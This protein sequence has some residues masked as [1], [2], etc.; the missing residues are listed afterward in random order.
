M[1]K[2]AKVYDDSRLIT[3]VKDTF[4]SKNVIDLKKP[5]KE[6]SE[7]HNLSR[8]TAVYYKTDHH[9]TAVGAYIGYQQ[10]AKVHNQGISAYDVQKLA[11][12]FYGTLYSKVM[13]MKKGGDS[14]YGPR[15]LVKV[16][17]N[18]GEKVLDSVYDMDK[19]N[20][21]DK[22]RI[23]FGGNFG[24]VDITTDNKNGKHLLIVK[25]SFANSFVPYILEAYDT[26]TMV[27]FRYFVENLKSLMKEKQVTEI[28]LLYEMSNFANDNNIYKISM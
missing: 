18:N 6:E 14:I 21:K 20:V 11:D 17:V 3:R 15:S 23:F 10:F 5:L 25:D 28:L 12:D 2:A 22:Y 24:Q 7:K 16:S 9:W 4:G 26:I 27:D 13:D 8:D 19:R 1:P